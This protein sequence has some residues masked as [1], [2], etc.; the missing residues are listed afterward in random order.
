EKILEALRRVPLF[1]E[2]EARQHL[3]EAFSEKNLKQIL[4]MVELHLLASRTGLGQVANAVGSI[5]GQ[6]LYGKEV[7][8]LGTELAEG[9]ADAVAAKDENDTNKASKKIT[10]VLVVAAALVGWA[11]VHKM[12]DFVGRLRGVPVTLK[13]V[14]NKP[15][16]YKKVGEAE[17]KRILNQF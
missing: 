1:A 13:G 12:G 8:N 17:A 15:V 6:L 4:L 16:T 14:K 5:L 10:T 3:Q 7:A 2:G 11:L 9:F